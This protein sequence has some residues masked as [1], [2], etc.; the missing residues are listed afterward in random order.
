MEGGV[1]AG[2]D[3]FV[4]RIAIGMHFQRQSTI[5]CTNQTDNLE[6]AAE[7][8]AG[9][10]EG[11]TALD[12]LDGSGFG[13]AQHCIE[14]FAVELTLQ[15]LVFFGGRCSRHVDLPASNTQPQ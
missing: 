5:S 6:E 8:G 9:Q 13:H 3:Y 11:G 15:V 2:R 14:V 7:H 10:T 12:L 1:E 4:P